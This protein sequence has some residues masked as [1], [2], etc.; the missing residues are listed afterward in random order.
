M[1][2]DHIRY[3]ILVQEALRGMV[4]DVLA[5]AAKNKACLASIIFSSPSTP[6]TKA[7]GCRRGCA[8]NTQKK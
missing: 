6:P 1:P 4:R 7:C 2:V 3:D 8:H 5:E